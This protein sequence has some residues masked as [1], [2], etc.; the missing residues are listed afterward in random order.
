MR[1][2]KEMEALEK[3]KIKFT[4]LARYHD[5]KIQLIKA[6]QNVEQVEAEVAKMEVIVN[7]CNES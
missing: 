6:R 1:I 3:E 4:H 2:T 7:Q 5:L